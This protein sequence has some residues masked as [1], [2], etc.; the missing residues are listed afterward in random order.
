MAEDAPA[1]KFIKPGSH[2]GKG[3][4]VFTSG[5]DSQGMNAAVR[6]V[7]RMGIYLGC[8]VYF[9][10]E[11][12]QGMVDGGKNIEEATWSSVSC[13]IHRGGTVIGSARCKEFRERPGR[14]KAAKNLVNLGITNLVVI[15]G[16][17]S[18]TGANLF[19]EE[20]PALLKELVE[21]GD[22]TAE[23]SEKYKQL[24]IVG[25]VGSIDNDFCGTDMTIGTDSAL[26]RIIESIDA[27]VST[28]Y[29]HQRTF[30]ME[31]M[32]RHCGYLAIVGALAAEADYVFFPE[33]PPPVDWPEK[34][35]KKLEQERLT[36]QRLNIIIVAEGAVDRNGDPITAEKV[37][38]VV[39][40]KLQQDTRIT[41]LGHVQRGGNPSAFDRVLGCRMGAE[42][43]MALMEATSDTEACVVTLDGNQAVRLPLMECVR[44]TKAVA[45]AMTDKN[46]DLAVQ[47]R[48]KGFA[49]NLETYKMLTR[50]KAPHLIDGAN[51]EINGRALSKD[52]YTLAVMHIGSPSCGMNAAVR[53]FVRNCIYRGDKVYGICDGVLG[54]IAGR[55][56]LMDWPSVTGWV[57]EGGAK[58]GTKRAPPT[59]DQL[60]QIAQRL[61]E[62]GI[63]AL[64]IIGGFEGYQ[65]S[66]TFFKARD[67]YE[68]FKIPIA[69]IPATISNN[70]PGTEFSLG[71]DTA[72]N[73]ITEICDRIRQSAQGTKRRVFII[74]T[75]GGFCGYLATVAGLAGGADAAYIYEEKFNIKDLNQDVI[76][77]AAK[78]SE[79][80]ERGLIIRNEN[81]NENYNTEFTFR[82]FSEEGKGLFSCRR[83]ILGHMQQGGSPT[84]FDRNLGTK[85]GSKAVE[86]FSDKLRK[87]TSPDGKTFTTAADSAVMLGIVRRQ[88]RY[89]PFTELIE[90]TDFEHR[91]PTY[92][93]WMKLRPLLK[94]L[95]K[96]ESTYEEEGLY[97]TVEEMDEQKDPPLV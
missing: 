97:I 48:G 6:A 78:M 67:K 65:T 57:S 66:L 62:F 17:G 7:V 21:S 69:M 83:N 11:G 88:Y 90:V 45:Q 37:H 52:N 58:L 14:R 24:H 12:Y 77:M 32:G 22:I 43:V 9:I 28:A 3:I 15:G 46:W 92:Q 31:V 29:S 81:A 86:W 72:L 13:I 30:I 61:K 34:L 75:M 42:A 23:Q 53:S 91:I 26:H 38:K 50:L 79:G 80:V 73:E 5:G 59:E 25:L 70:V 4:A 96:H 20:W 89:T 44:R 27:I 94:V 35:C 49:R 63:Q 55:L 64:L 33:C 54:L 95:A 18:L 10:R 36:G 19:K 2:K 82:L 47:L 68:E 60:P 56:K 84:P 41:V 71:C 39:V 74:E 1:Q 51:R 8:R 76:A 85:M 40:E 87:C 93:W 16:D